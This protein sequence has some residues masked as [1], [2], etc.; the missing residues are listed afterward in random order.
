MAAVR[1]L[2]SLDS[3]AAIAASIQLVASEG[4]ETMEDVP[5]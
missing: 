1:S 5:A 3:A 4:A 2:T